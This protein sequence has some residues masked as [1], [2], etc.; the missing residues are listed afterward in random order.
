[1]PKV[2]YLHGFASSS[3][4]EK[5]I[6]LQESL[7]DSFISPDLLSKPSIDVNTIDNIIK[8]EG[9]VILVGASLGGFY[10]EYF[11]C[12]YKLP[13]LLIN[14]LLDVTLIK[15]YIGEHQYYYKP[16]SFH[17]TDRDYLTLLKMEKELV[18]YKQYCQKI[19][20]LSEKDTVIDHR[21]AIDYYDSSEISLKVFEDETH[22]FSNIPEILKNIEI[23]IEL[24][25]NN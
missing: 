5:V 2:I 19:V 11:S 1:M 17:F 18:S 4:S 3:K 25:F 23:L 12:K 6:K 21:I 15:P 16:K 13:S 20:I 22:S 14:P 24:T 7:G 10:A 8:R 9:E